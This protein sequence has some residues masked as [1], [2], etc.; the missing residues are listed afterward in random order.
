MGDRDRERLPAPIEVVPSRPFYGD[1]SPTAAFVSQ[2]LAERQ[3]LQPQRSK[4]R[5]TPLEASAA[6]ATGKTISV[7]RLPAGYRRTIV[8]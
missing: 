1:I 6:Y 7:R 2:L 8:A 4:R 5:S 3:H